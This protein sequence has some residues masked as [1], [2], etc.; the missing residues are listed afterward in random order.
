M[1]LTHAYFIL[2]LTLPACLLGQGSDFIMGDLNQVTGTRIV[3]PEKKFPVHSA[4]Q[5]YSDGT[6]LSVAIKVIDPSINNDPNPAYADRVDVWLAL[7]EFAFPKS[8]QYGFHPRLLSAPA[9]RERGMDTGVNRLFSLNEESAANLTARGFTRNFNYPDRE[10]IR[11]KNLNLPYPGSFREVLMPFGI[12]QFSF[13]RDGR[14]PIHANE[15]V[16]RDL[17]DHLGR[18]LSPLTD[19]VRY[20]SDPTEREDGYIINIEF[21]I[22]AF[23]F[24][25][26][27]E[28]QGINLMVDVVNANPGQRGRIVNSTANT[29][30]IHPLNFQYV[31]FQRPIKTNYTDLSDEVFTE[32][33]FYPLMWYSENDWE[34]FGIDVDGLVMENGQL[35]ED[36]LEVKVYEQSLLFENFEFEGYEIDLIKTNLD[37][38]NRVGVEKDIIRANGQNIIAEKVRRNNRGL[39]AEIEDRWFLFEDGTLGLIYEESIPRHSFGWGNCGSCRIETINITRI[40]EAAVWDI[41]EIEQEEG[42]NGYC[43][44]KDLSYQNFYVSNFDWVDEGSRLI[45]RLKHRSTR[46]KKRVE[47]SWDEY[48]TSLEVKELE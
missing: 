26:L 35:S 32:N 45:L 17:E 33:D 37:F 42:S 11:D 4:V 16:L 28:M 41:L 12:T 38:V 6:Y 7:P 22:E 46:E 36:L 39:K 8:Y 3:E 48:G 10:E 18:K 31:S 44:I 29:R 23:G 34:G 30:S 25:I 1:K 13:F 20:T 27:P 47:V 24:V 9:V 2:I 14:D 43:Q 40:S 5:V 21:S 15:Y 19:G